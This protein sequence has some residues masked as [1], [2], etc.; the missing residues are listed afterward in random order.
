M[1]KMNSTHTVTVK[2]T[3]DHAW[4]IIGEDFVAVDRWMAANPSADAIPGAALPGA[5]AKGRNSNLIQKFQPMYQEEIITAY[6]DANRSISTRVTLRKTPKIM[7]MLGYVATVTVKQVDAN[8]C[9]I[10]YTGHA[11]TKWYT[12]P[13]KGMLTKTLAPGFLRGLEE[14]AHYIETGEPHPRKIEKTKSESAL[15]AV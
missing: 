10:I 14:L 4:K 1:L 6:S 13:M 11:L 5:P 9:T 2:A 15:A 12:K 7:P 8:T 3:A